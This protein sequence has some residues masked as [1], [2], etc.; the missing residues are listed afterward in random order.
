MKKYI[1]PA[2]KVAIIMEP[3]LAALSLHNTL[4]E[5]QLGNES[6]FD[7]EEPTGKSI[8]VWE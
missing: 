7:S 3:L 8:N 5:E 4:G 6:S 1:R 2:I